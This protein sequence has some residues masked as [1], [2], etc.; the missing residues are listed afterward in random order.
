MPAKDRI[1]RVALNERRRCVGTAVDQ[2][3]MAL[4]SA[5]FVMG[6]AGRTLSKGLVIIPKSQPGSCSEP[7]DRE[8]GD[9]VLTEKGHV[10]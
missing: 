4:G 2:D 9:M 1:L 7:T 8:D 5:T 10:D 3:R 6:L